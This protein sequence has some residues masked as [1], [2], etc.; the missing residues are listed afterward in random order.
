MKEL[1]G[2]GRSGDVF[3]AVHSETGKVVAVKVPSRDDE[4]AYA[5]WNEMVQN[6]D[7]MMQSDTRDR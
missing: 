3:R 7:L 5:I 1:L 6:D 4:G 2:Y